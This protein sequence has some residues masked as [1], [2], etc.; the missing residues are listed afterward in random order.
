MKMEMKTILSVLLTSSP[1]VAAVPCSAAN[2]M[3]NLPDAK[4]HVFIDLSGKISEGDDKKFD[5]VLSNILSKNN[6][7]KSL[8]LRLSSEGGS[9]L[10]A[11]A[12]AESVSSAGPA[13]Y[14]PKNASC[15]VPALSSGSPGHLVPSTRMVPL[16]SIKCMMEIPSKVW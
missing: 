7:P 10:P 14:A 16:D 4:G 2:I 1:L 6:N 9:F 3:P 13:T 5:N 15:A 11:I 8:I 12:I